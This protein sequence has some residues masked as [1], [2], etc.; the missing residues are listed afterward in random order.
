MPHRVLKRRRIKIIYPI[1]EW[2]DKISQNTF[3]WDSARNVNNFLRLK[4]EIVEKDRENSE[5]YLKV[6]NKP[7]Y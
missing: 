2:S 3:V 4:G 1:K 7:T 5:I 6:I